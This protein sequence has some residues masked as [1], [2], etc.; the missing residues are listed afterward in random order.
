MSVAARRDE[1]DRAVKMK[2]EHDRYSGSIEHMADQIGHPP[3]GLRRRPVRRA[4]AAY[5]APDKRGN[6]LKMQAVIA[7]LGLRERSELGR[8]FDGVMQKPHW[9][10]QEFTYAVMHMESRP[11]WVFVL[12]SCVGI[13]PSDLYER[14][15]I[16]ML[17]AM[18][19]YRKTHCFRIIDREKLSY[20]VGLR[21]QESP[22][23]SPPEI[24]LG[25]D[26]RRYRLPATRCCT[27]WIADIR[28]SHPFRIAF[29]R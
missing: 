27:P 15:H 17:A 7:N 4:L 21:E 14:E 20:E 24:A 16:L 18:A 12:G 26:L 11:D 22:P 23:S 8:A 9:S 29:D 3:R 13:A 2:K 28:C 6:Y 1:L 19:F 25:G 5:G 10:R